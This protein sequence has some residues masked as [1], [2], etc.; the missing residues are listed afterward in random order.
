MADIYL[1]EFMRMFEHY[2][3]RSK[4]ADAKKKGQPD[5]SINLSETDAWT[6]PYYDPKDVKCLERKFFAGVSE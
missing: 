5:N 6:A 1:T 4:Q 3:F 2:L